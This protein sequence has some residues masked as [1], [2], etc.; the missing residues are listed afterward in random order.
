VEVQAP[1][2]VVERRLAV[3][4]AQARELRRSQVLAKR[5]AKWRVAWA[6]TGTGGG[7]ISSAVYETRTEAMTA[8]EAMQAHPDLR[9]LALWVERVSQ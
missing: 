9:H 7:G 3:E 1:D 8:M 4:A 6:D 2:W 5:Y